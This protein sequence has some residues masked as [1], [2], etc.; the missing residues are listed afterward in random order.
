MTTK[1]VK[2]T[3][4][5]LIR[6]CQHCGRHIP[7]GMP[8]FVRKPPHRRAAGSWCSPKCAQLDNRQSRGVLNHYEPH[9]KGR[10]KIWLV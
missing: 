4:W 5:Q 2:R 9:G 7:V 6:T 1:I 10:T 8:Y 3:N